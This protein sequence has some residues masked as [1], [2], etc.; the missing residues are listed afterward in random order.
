M[1]PD[2]GQGGDSKKGRNASPLTSSDT[3]RLPC[4]QVE[5][6]GRHHCGVLTF[7]DL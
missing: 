3:R 2:D 6:D 1:S 4:V 5:E 7:L